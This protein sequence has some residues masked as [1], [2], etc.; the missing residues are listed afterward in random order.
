MTTTSA[1]RLEVVT[2]EIDHADVIALVEQPEESGHLI[3][4]LI[5]LIVAATIVGAVVMALR[6]RRS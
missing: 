3:R 2:D 4:N 5:V 6:G 1:E